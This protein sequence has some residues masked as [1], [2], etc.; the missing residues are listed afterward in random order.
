[1]REWTSAEPF[2]AQAPKQLGG[3]LRAV[4]DSLYIYSNACGELL[5]GW[6]AALPGAHSSRSA[7][8][9]PSA[10]VSNTGWTI[11]P[12]NQWFER[13]LPVG[14]PEQMGTELLDQAAYKLR[15]SDSCANL[16]A[17]MSS[18]DP[19]NLWDSPFALGFLSVGIRRLCSS[20]PCVVEILDSYR[21]DVLFLGSGGQ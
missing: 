9:N 11:L 4:L 5:P 21:P 13:P 17:P 8:T 2:T 1:M 10:V 12:R 15:T 7:P 18:Q 19:P 16:S 3:M 14:L 6:A 20:I